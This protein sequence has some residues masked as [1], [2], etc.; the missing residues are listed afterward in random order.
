MKRAEFTTTILLYGSLAP[1]LVTLFFLLVKGIEEG[2][3]LPYVMML[4][5]PGCISMYI[6]AHILYKAIKT[7]NKVKNNIWLTAFYLVFLSYFFFGLLSAIATGIYEPHKAFKDFESFL[8]MSLS[9]GG[10]GFIATFWLSIPIG[11]YGLKKTINTNEQFNPDS[12]ADAPPPV[13]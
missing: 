13:N 12:G 10:M 5:I 7:R 9:M 6:S 11:V 3:I 8:L 4:F 1:L 2:N